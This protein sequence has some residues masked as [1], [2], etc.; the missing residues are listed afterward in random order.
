M[1]KIAAILLAAGKGRRME[2][3][4]RKQYMLLDGKPLIW[5][6]LDAFEKSPVDEIILVVG[7]GEIDPGKRIVADFGF[8]KVTQV[9][10]G[11]AERYDSVYEGLKVLRDADYVLIHDGA[12][13]FVTEKIIKDNIETAERERACATAMPVK[14]TVK[15]VDV[16]GYAIYTPA[17]EHVWL[18][19]TPQTFEY[20]LIREAYEKLMAK[21][22]KEVTDDAMIVERLMRTKVKLVRGSYENIKI[23]TPDDLVA[24]Q[25]FVGEKNC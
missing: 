10:E 4:V 17:R 22:E 18:A 9:I 24:A 21:D 8:K 1:S 25:G 2:S 15:M 14:D 11:G 19:Q 23:T 3:D 16:E 6:A 13:P 5:Y 7:K 12:R 20:S